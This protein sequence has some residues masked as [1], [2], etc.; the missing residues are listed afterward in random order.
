MG[1]D[2]KCGC[3][4]SFGHWF[5]CSKHED[6]IIEEEINTESDLSNINLH[7]VIMFQ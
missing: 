2:F 5:L 4:V 6:M 3:R 7:R 1:E